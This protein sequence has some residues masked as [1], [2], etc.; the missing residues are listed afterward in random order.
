MKH[1]ESWLKQGII[2]AIPKLEQLSQGHISAKLGEA[3]NLPLHEL[4]AFTGDETRFVTGIA[5]T[6][7]ENPSVKLLILLSEEASNSIILS[8]IGQDGLNDNSLGNSILQEIGNIF[9]SAIA[10][11]ISKNNNMPV[12]TSIPEIGHDMVGAMISAIISDLAFLEDSVAIINTT[13]TVDKED[14]DC[15]IY[16]FSDSVNNQNNNQNIIIGGLY[17]E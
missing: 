8:I 12:K 16:L 13:F 14:I 10:N 11:C 6:L 7:L 2:E 5:M 15:E 3:S 4:P 17:E 1:L 9:G